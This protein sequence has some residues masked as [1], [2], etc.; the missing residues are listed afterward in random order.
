M[1][2]ID[3]KGKMPQKLYKKYF[4]KSIGSIKKSAK[5]GKKGA[6]NK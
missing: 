1:S 6:G 3:F 5:K 2:K 4:E